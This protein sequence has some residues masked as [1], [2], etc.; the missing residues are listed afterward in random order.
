[1]AYNFFS[2]FSNSAQVPLLHRHQHDLCRREGQGQLPGISPPTHRHHHNHHY[3]HDH[4]HDHPHDAHHPQ[5][6]SGGPLVCYNPDG[7]SYLGGVVR[8]I[9][10][11][12]TEV[13]QLKL[14]KIQEVASQPIPPPP[15]NPLLNKQ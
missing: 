2:S 9:L 1:M 15:S 10:A 4:H 7:S 6:D 11:A 8:Y 13:I 3:Y 12:I 5:G 14:I